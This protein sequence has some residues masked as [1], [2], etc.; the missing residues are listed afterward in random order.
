ML[1]MP[2]KSEAADLRSGLSVFIF[3]LFEQ[4]FSGEACEEAEE[5][6]ND[7]L[8][9]LRCQFGAQDASTES[10]REVSRDCFT[11]IYLGVSCTLCRW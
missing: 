2:W 9:G 1:F 5:W 8:P 6:R 3:R 4:A 7:R 10:C 11:S